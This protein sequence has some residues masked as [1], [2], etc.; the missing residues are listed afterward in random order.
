MQD[1]F[2]TTER[3]RKDPELAR[4]KHVPIIAVTA[5]GADG[6]RRRALEV[7]MD[8]FTLKPLHAEYLKV[9]LEMALRKGLERVAAD[10]T[11]ETER[12]L[13]SIEERSAENTTEGSVTA[14]EEDTDANLAMAAETQG[15]SSQHALQGD[16]DGDSKTI[17]ST[18]SVASSAESTSARSARTLQ[19][20]LP[21]GD[22]PGLTITSATPIE[23]EKE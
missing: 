7:G 15:M 9:L 11:T 18:K 4:F 2:Q 8:D 20:I 13:Q 6:D 21:E 22:V 10:K 1:G 19:L 17:R 23:S 3:I 5:S 14:L 12:G 16:G